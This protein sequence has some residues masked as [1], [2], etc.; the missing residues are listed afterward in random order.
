MDR[1]AEEL[2]CGDIVIRKQAIELGRRTMGAARLV[3]GM[4]VLLAATATQAGNTGHYFASL[5]NARDTVMP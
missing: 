3:L 1:W 2:I 5:P 4:A